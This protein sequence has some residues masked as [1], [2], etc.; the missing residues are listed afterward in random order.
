MRKIT[1]DDILCTIIF[2]VA[3]IPGLILKQIKR[4]IWLIAERPNIAGDNGLELYKWIRNNRPV[5]EAYFVLDKNAWNFDHND[6]HMIPWRSFKHFI[7]Y[8]ASDKHV[9][10]MFKSDKINTRV[11]YYFEKICKRNLRIAYIR[12]GIHK[13]GIEM[14]KYSVLG[15]RL[16]ICGAKPEYDY[17]RENAGYPDE[18]LVYT[19]FARFD[20]L[21]EN[22]RDDRYILIIP[23]WRRY[24]IDHSLSDTEN[25]KNFL[26]STYYEHYKAL[27]E[28][29]RLN[30]FLAQTRLIAKFCIH[31]EFRRFEHLFSSHS[32]YIKIV[33]LDESIHELLLSNSLLVTD[34]SSVFFDA[35][36]A[37]KPMV[38]YHFDYEEFRGKHFSEGYFSYE[39]DAMGPVVYE[40]EDL[41]NRIVDSWDG[42]KFDMGEE[43]RRRTE[44]FFPLHDTN[45]C[46]RIYDAISSI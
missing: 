19:G 17:F 37:D 12:H 21:L 2:I 41:V 23:T 38:F 42:E 31:A 24:L 40:Q 5:Q 13:D 22:K 32:P 28:D 20:D 9:N 16:F 43:Y 14:H 29:K 39:R 11:C 44:R 27:L 6:K 4:D 36:Y 15:V 34:Y 7:L 45:N 3:L 35:A 26:K 25:E 8:I 1:L 30:D 33:G 10:T 18:N 46:Q